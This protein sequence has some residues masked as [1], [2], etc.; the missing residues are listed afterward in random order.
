MS[1]RF[2][3]IDLQPF[4]LKALDPVFK[5]DLLSRTLGFAHNLQQ[6]QIQT[7]CLTFNLSCATVFMPNGVPPDGKTLKDFH[8]HP[9]FLG[10][11][12]D[13]FNKAYADGFKELPPDPDDRDASLSLNGVLRRLACDMPILSGVATRACV[14]ATADG[15]LRNGYPCIVAYDL[16]GDDRATPAQNRSPAWHKEKLETSFA[17]KPYR[18]LLLASAQILEL[19]SDKPA[20]L[21]A[22][23]RAGAHASSAVFLPGN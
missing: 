23:S 4:W 9:I 5:E 15:G 10:H 12:F 18:P 20:L 11:S 2:L 17:D 1:F 13:F 7:L 6:I 8:V 14:S 21:A 16:C 19:L 22:P 3:P